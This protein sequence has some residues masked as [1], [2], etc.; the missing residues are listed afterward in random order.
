MARYR[1]RINWKNL[2]AGTL[3]VLVVAGAVFGLV[4]ITGKD[5]RS[6]GGTAFSVG[7]IDAN[8]KGIE[9]KT[10]IYTKDKISCQ[11]LSIV[12]EFDSS[13]EYQVFFYNEDDH[14]L[15]STAKRSDS[16]TSSE[17]PACAQY[18]RI[19]IYPSTLGEDGKEIKDFKVRLWDV[20]GIA[21]DIKITV[22]K[23]QLTWNVIA[24]ATSVDY[25]SSIVYPPATNVVIEDATY[26]VGGSKWAAITA[27]EDGRVLVMNVSELLRLKAVVTSDTALTIHFVDAQGTVVADTALAAAKTATVDVP[28]G[29][30][31]A[32]LP[33]GED[34]EVVLTE[35]LPRG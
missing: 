9:V 21:N 6:I 29:A 26:N 3:A 28:T 27:S 11:G 8:G 10:S 4:K 20:L 5:T 7:A 24:C 18:A 15:S 35:Y 34:A 23:E 14:F 33:L 16:F 22:A 25:S 32:I 17:I 31:Y 12:P 2:I 1:K 13:S 19:V 30:A